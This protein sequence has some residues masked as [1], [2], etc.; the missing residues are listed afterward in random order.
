MVTRLVCVVITALVLSSC[1]PRAVRLC[2]AE[3]ECEGCSETEFDQCVRDRDD[4]SFE[5]D[6]E[7]C[8]PEHRDLV[9]CENA[10]WVCDGDDFDTDCGPEERA[11]DECL[12]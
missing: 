3:C 7:D 12:D 11:L 4:D 2:D 1:A 5:A 10:T 6:R 8:A 9:A